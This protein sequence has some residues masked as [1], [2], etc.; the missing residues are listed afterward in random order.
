[1]NRTKRDLKVYSLLKIPISFKQLKMFSSDV[2]WNKMGSDWAMKWL[3]LVSKAVAAPT[4]PKDPTC[5]QLEEWKKSSR[6]R[7]ES[8]PIFW[9]GSSKQQTHRQSNSSNNSLYTAQS[10]LFY[11]SYVR[12]NNCSW[13][14][15]SHSDDGWA[16]IPGEGTPFLL[17]LLHIC[18]SGWW[19]ADCPDLT[20]WH[21]LKEQEGLGSSAQVQQENQEGRPTEARR[22]EDDADGGRN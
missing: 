19:P 5:L 20:L 21:N 1:M 8:L 9:K 15:T 3:S 22:H 2:S 12:D 7:E 18:G 10:G 17:Q 4:V 11:W 6:Q 16:E 13:T 14:A